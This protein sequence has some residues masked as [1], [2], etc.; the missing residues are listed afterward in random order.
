[1]SLGRHDT[2]QKAPALLSDAGPSL[3]LV[4]LRGCLWKVSD[5]RLCPCPAASSRHSSVCVTLMQ[6]APAS[7]PHHI[8]RHILYRVSKNLMKNSENQ[9]QGCTAWRPLLPSYLKNKCCHSQPAEASIPADSRRP[10]QLP[11]EC[12]VPPCLMNHQQ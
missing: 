1:M 6:V 5:W 4:P 10:R 11:R 3:S 8:Y 7:S 2:A 9:Q 12:Q